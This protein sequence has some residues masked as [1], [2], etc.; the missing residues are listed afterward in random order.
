MSTLSGPVQVKHYVLFCLWGLSPLAWNGQGVTPPAGRA[1]QP[2]QGISQRT[3]A[4]FRFVNAKRFYRA[5]EFSE[6]LARIS[7]TSYLTEKGWRNHSLSGFVDKA[8]RMV[9]D[10]HFRRASKFSHGLAAACGQGADSCG[11]IDRQGRWTIP[12]HFNWTEDFSEG[13]AMV[14]LAEG[15]VAYIDQHGKVVLNVHLLQPRV[16]E[17]GRFSHG[18]AQIELWG[19]KYI[20]K[21]NN[22]VQPPQ[23]GADSAN[24]TK[25]RDTE[26]LVSGFIDREGKM[27]I[28][29]TF[30]YVEAFSEG[31]A[32]VVVPGGGYGYIDTLGTMIIPPRFAVA[33]SFSEGLAAVRVGTQYGYINRQGRL[34]IAPQF[35]QALAFAEGLAPVKIRGGDWGYID[36]MGRMVIAPQFAEAR[37]FSEG[38]AAVKGKVDYSQPILSRTLDVWRY[39]SH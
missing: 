3:P 14:R 13:L 5:D 15:S 26:S 36:Q 32:L 31:L 17:A 20:D 10:T 21:Q 4:S 25:V 19:E 24:A 9:I 7:P 27:M 30:A 1:S 34:T 35:S 6:G 33:R 37:P 12:P 22:V 16:H 29:A 8:G 38:V 18:L 39:I 2:R 28:A 23:T 11:Y